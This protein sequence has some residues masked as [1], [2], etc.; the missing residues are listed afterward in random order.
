MF[1]PVKAMEESLKLARFDAMPSAGPLGY[2]HVAGMMVQVQERAMSDD[3]LN[4]FLGWMQC[5]IV[6]AYPRDEQLAMHEKM[7]AINVL[8]GSKA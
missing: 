6:A 1:N 5:A 2:P 7:K 8:C 3:K 4:R